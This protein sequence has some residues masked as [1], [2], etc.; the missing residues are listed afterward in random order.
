MDRASDLL[1]IFL[2]ELFCAETLLILVGG[3]H[4]CPLLDGTKLAVEFLRKDSIF[5]TRN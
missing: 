3:K 1:L 5:L 4:D 2:L